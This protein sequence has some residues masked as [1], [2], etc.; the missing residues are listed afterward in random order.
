MNKLFKPTFIFAFL[1]ALI[2]S[3][4]VTGSA[5]A[6]MIRCR[7]DPLVLLSDGTIVDISADV[8][9]LL[10]NIKSVDYVLHIPAGLSAVI[11]LSTPNWPTTIEHFTIYADNPPGTYSSYTT[12]VTKSSVAV[13]ANMVVNQNMDSVDGFSGDALY[14]SLADDLLP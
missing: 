5:K 7:A 10:F 9:T 14:L 11:T 13:T 8:S 3:G 12:V 1:L 6:D 2:L 4:L